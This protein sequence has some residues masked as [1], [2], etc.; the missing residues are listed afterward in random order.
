MR[1]A[2]RGGGAALARYA[3]H[4]RTTPGRPGDRGPR[5]EAARVVHRLQLLAL[6]LSASAIDRRVRAGRLHRIHVGVYAVGHTRLTRHGRF[7]AAILAC[8]EGAVLSHRSA[9]ALWGLT[10]EAPVRVDVTR[11]GAGGHK[12]PGITFHRTRRL[13]DHE[14]TT[15]DGIPVTSV[16]RTLLD[17]IDV[18]SIDSPVAKADRRG[19][20]DPAAVHRAIADNP[21]RR[22]TKRL[23]AAVDAPMLTRSELEEA[24]LALVRRAH[25]PIPLVNHRVAGIE[26]DFHWPDHRLVVETDGAAFH[27]DRAAQERDREREALLARAGQRTHR[28][29][30]RQVLHDPREVE[31]TLR[32]LLGAVWS[33]TVERERPTPPATS[34]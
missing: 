23:L 14:R 16:A 10:R 3:T 1:G 30:H 29:T 7:M 5:D 15:V 11:I 25:L 12:R 34:V 17:L 27:A 9:S 24:F 4:I 13:P 33:R 31:A 2:N 20:L 21:G 26:V 6:G 19:V 8:G 32:A 28:F 22:G 18:M